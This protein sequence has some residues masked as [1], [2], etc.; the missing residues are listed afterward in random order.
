MSHNRR[1]DDEQH[2]EA[3]VVKLEGL[4]G[5]ERFRDIRELARLYRLHSAQLVRLQTQARDPQAVRYCNALC[6]RAYNLIYNS[7]RRRADRGR[8]LLADLPDTLALT[9]RLQAIVA[10]LLLISI[11]AGLSVARGDPRTLAALIP[12]YDAELL[13]KLASSSEARLEFLERRETSLAPNSFFGTYLFFN[14]TRVG[15]MSFATGILAGLPSVLLVLYNGLTLG[16][17]IS[18]FTGQPES[19]WFWAWIIPHG[20]PELLAIVLC[21]TG[22]LV[23]GLALVAPGRAGRVRALREAGRHALHLLMASIPLFFLA[24]LIESFVRQ[25]ALSTEVRFGV[26]FL[27]AASIVGYVVIVR[28][29]AKRSARPDLSFLSDR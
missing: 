16:A 27:A 10:V 15:L 24:A 29:L 17:F 20:I 2:F 11:L 9:W 5:R 23:L 14:N 21:S 3:L 13:E 26:A 12:L 28:R 22:G 6:V 25:S 7:P 1:S 8:F 19:L 18:I 4:R